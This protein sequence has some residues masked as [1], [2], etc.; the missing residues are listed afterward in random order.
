M[1][2]RI[3]DVWARPEHVYEDDHYSSS[4]EMEARGEDSS[5]Y[6][7]RNGWEGLLVSLNDLRSSSE[8]KL[9]SKFLPFTASF[10]RISQ[11][12]RII[13]EHNERSEISC[14]SSPRS[15]NFNP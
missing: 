11:T 6:K 10:S 15:T 4:K 1:K 13:L 14:D 2:P 8:W 3:W 12:P 5:D 9:K 7:E